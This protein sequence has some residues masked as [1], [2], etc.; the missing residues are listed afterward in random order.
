MD[1]LSTTAATPLAAKRRAST[2]LKRLRVLLVLATTA[3]VSEVAVCGEPTPYA[4]AILTAR[5]FAEDA[6]MTLSALPR[7]A[8]QIGGLRGRIGTEYRLALLY[9]AMN[10]DVLAARYWQAMDADAR[11]AGDNPARGTALIAQIYATFISGDYDSGQLLNDQLIEVAQAANSERMSA[12][13]QEY[14]GVR[15]RRHGQLD[16]ARDHQLHALW[17]YRLIGDAAGESTVLTNLGTIARDKGDFAQ[18]LDYFLQALAIRER[19]DVRLAVAYRNLALLYRELGDVQTT[20][21]YFEKALDASNH[22]FEAEYY[23]STIGVYAAFLNDIG[24]Y[25]PA[26]DKASEALIIS[27]ALGDR[28][29]T[30]FEQLEVGRAQLGLHRTDEAEAHF[31]DAL[32]IGQT[33]QQRELIAR[34][35]LSLAEIALGHGDLATTHRLLDETAPSLNSAGLKAYLAQAYSLRDRLAVAEHIPAVAYE[36]AHRYSALREELLGVRSTRLLAAIE[37]RKIREQSQQK[38]E[39]AESI[40]ELQTE[41][42]ERGRHERYYSIAAIVALL[43]IL[44]LFS[45]FLVRFRRLNHALSRHNEQ[46]ERQ[47]GALIEANRQLERQAHSLYQATITDALTGTR[48]RSHTLDELAR[49]LAKCRAQ[50]RNLTVLLI[51]IDHFKQVNDRFGHLAGDRALIQTSRI[52]DAALP[53]DCLFGRFGGEEFVV[54][55]ADHDDGASAELAER[56][57]RAVAEPMPDMAMAITISIGGAML[58]DRPAI[59]AIDPLLDAADHALYQA[60]LDG[61]NRIRGFSPA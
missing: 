26:L 59:K 58:K 13:A 20:R 53:A 52:I 16:I 10:D 50:R 5:Q 2:T 51:D 4:Q 24:E 31:N 17:L 11:R 54:A 7:V 41:R 8:Y 32:R 30:G 48:S 47:R 6:D 56:I 15:D 38:L 60:K 29:S 49:L 45:A 1:S 27:A 18:C 40:N 36:Y 25:G 46:F 9:A 39:L 44:A 21:Q 3:L 55:F 23:A 43:A 57:R 42:L 12:T 33:I 34:A 35:K 28:P 14:Q 37:I 22:H 61:R 19:I